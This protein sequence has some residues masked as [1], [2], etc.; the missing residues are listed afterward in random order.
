MPA[1]SLSQFRK[2]EVGMR[3]P[4]RLALGKAVFPLEGA[5]ELSRV[6]FIKSS[7]PV[8]RALSS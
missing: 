6:P 1:I 7:I 5:R 3:V 8:M 4:V 2:V